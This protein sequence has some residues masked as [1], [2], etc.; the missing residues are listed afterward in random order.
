MRKILSNKWISI[1]LALLCTV[2]WGSAYPVIKLAYRE[3]SIAETGDKLLFAG[4]RFAI[5]GVMVFIAA[6]IIRRRVPLIGRDRWGWVLLLGAVQTGLMYFF[7]YIGVSN[8]T[9]TKTS[10]LTAL[11][12]FL[13]VLIAPLF[14]KGERLSPYKIIGIIL[15]FAGIMA[16]NFSSFDFSFSLIG[17]GF[18]ILATV[19][20]TAGGF[21]SKKISKGK[22]FETTAYQLFFGGVMLI[23]AA[24]IM[25]WSVTITPT[26]VW[27][28]LYLAFVS[29]A[30][31]TIW[32]ALL[33][34]NEAGQILIFNLFIP[35]TGAVWSYLVLGEREIFDPM[36]LISVVLISAGILL[37]NSHRKPRDNSTD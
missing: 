29:A 3:L 26:G 14:F 27:I 8:T 35:V 5:A 23:L 33:V 15:G 22:V 21:L 17:E 28:T 30:A 36:Y 1:I 32:T 12:A 9:A 6:L 7:N 13:S 4:I 16:V 20:N 34:Y 11:S 10:V 18:I 31:F 2:L 37:V 19:L 25:G 24:C